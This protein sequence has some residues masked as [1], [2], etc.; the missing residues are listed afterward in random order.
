MNR[1]QGVVVLTA[2][3]GPAVE[4]KVIPLPAVRVHCTSRDLSGTLASASWVSSMTTGTETGEVLTSVNSV[5]VDTGAADV[6]VALRY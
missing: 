2:P 1:T 3:R 5:Y 4:W 6:H